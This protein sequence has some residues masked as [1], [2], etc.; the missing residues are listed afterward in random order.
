VD[1]RS[2]YRTII[3]QVLAQHAEHVASHGQ[4]EALP[5]FDEEHEQYLLIDVGWDSTGRVHAVTVHLR[6][7]ADQVWVEWDGLETGA[8]Q[9]LLDAGIPP[10][11]IILAFYR[12]VRPATW[13]LAQA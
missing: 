5:V 8:T 1:K 9:D 10:E 11:D 6:L 4:I 12:P 2:H 7:K 13:A 3:K